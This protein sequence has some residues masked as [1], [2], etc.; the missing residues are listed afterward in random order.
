MAEAGYL[1]SGQQMIERSLLASRELYVNGDGRQLKRWG[2]RALVEF[3]PRPGRQW[4]ASTTLRL[5][6]MAH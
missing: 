3:R 4:P 6:F 2:H 1:L 5:L